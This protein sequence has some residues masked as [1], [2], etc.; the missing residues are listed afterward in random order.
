MIINGLNNI[1]EDS[2][3]IR[4]KDNKKHYVHFEGDD[5]TGENVIYIFKE[6]LIGACVWKLEKAKAF[7][8]QSG[9]NNLEYIKVSEVLGKDASF[10]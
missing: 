8:K 4:L 2:Y 5:K 3:F 7:I 10:N 6:T 9:A 1:G